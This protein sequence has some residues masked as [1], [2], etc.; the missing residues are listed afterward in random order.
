MDGLAI[1]V[2]VGGGGIGWQRW[3]GCGEGG[4]SW[5]GPG[6]CCSARVRTMICSTGIA[7]TELL[8]EWVVRTNGTLRLVGDLGVRTEGGWLG[9]LRSWC[10]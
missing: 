4:W 10:S 6:G 1:G 7:T 3:D 8:S 9:D 2:V 5:L